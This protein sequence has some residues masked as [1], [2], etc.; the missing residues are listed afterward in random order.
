M[1]A[2]AWEGQR[3]PSLPPWT[4]R[5]SADQAARRDRGATARG[6]LAG[7]LV[8][9]SLHANDKECDSL[10]GG[11]WEGPWAPPKGGRTDGELTAPIFSLE[12]EVRTAG[13]SQVSEVGAE[14]RRQH[15]VPMET[16]RRNP[17]GQPTTATDG[18]RA[19]V[20]GCGPPVVRSLEAV[21]RAGGTYCMPWG[22]G[23]RV[24]LED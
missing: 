8:L 14:Q 12:Q 5:H 24:G 20:L 13:T 22:Q 11:S 23:Q 7:H 9:L 19:S 17:A 10:G 6:H 16:G 4:H 3:P 15:T 21:G 18:N 2:G 1:R